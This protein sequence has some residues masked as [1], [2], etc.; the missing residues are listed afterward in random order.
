MNVFPS[1]EEFLLLSE[2]PGSDRPAHRNEVLDSRDREDL[3][4]CPPGSNMW[5]TI[6]RDLWFR[7]EIAK[8]NWTTYGDQGPPVG[9]I[10]ITLQSGC[11]GGVG[12]RRSLKGIYQEDPR[13]FEINDKRGST[14]LLGVAYWWIY[15]GMPKK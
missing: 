9:S 1:L 6:A 11:G 13:F 5:L 7:Y 3:E 12:L 14:Y 15:M 8:R 10:I 4:G 2:Y